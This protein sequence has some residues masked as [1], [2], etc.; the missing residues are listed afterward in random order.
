DV[1]GIG[2]KDRIPQTDVRNLSRE[3]PFER[4]VA[5]AL[6]LDGTDP[7]VEDVRGPDGPLGPEPKRAQGGD[8]LA[9]AC[10]RVDE[11]VEPLSGGRV[12]AHQRGK[13]GQEPRGSRE[14]AGESDGRGSGHGEEPREAQG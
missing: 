4:P 2:L 3:P 7:G 10:A 13:A 5:L 1:E 8:R 9:V 12:K 11:D 6:E 14:V